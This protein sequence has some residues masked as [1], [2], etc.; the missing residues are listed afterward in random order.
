M[1]G[2]LTVKVQNDTIAFSM[3]N[4][5][6]TI[7]RNG[8]K[9]VLGST[10]RIYVPAGESWVII[11][12]HIERLEGVSLFC[13]IKCLLFLRINEYMADISFK[14]RYQ[15]GEVVSKERTGI[16]AGNYNSIQYAL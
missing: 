5:E 8:D 6:C 16:T 13:V 10:E 9:F 15:G 1:D 7:Y 3:E 2:T 11:R 4:V 12:G 14:V